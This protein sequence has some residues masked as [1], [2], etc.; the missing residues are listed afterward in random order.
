MKMMHLGHL[1][2]TG[3]KAGGSLNISFT[4]KIEQG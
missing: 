2:A 1:K 4:D 3:H